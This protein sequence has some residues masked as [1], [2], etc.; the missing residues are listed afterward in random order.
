MYSHKLYIVQRAKYNKYNTV[1]MAV[2]MHAKKYFLPVY[3]VLQSLCKMKN[4]SN[5]CMHNILS[6]KSKL[7]ACAGHSRF[8][9]CQAQEHKLPAAKKHLLIIH[10][11]SMSF[12]YT[13][14]CSIFVGLGI[15][16]WLLQMCCT[17]YL[18]TRD[19][20]EKSFSVV[21]VANV[22]Y[23]KISYSDIWHFLTNWFAQLIKLRQILGHTFNLNRM[24]IL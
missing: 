10:C 2:G 14:A 8:F 23:L 9:T 7:C 1:L 4:V 6:S 12:L 17:S 15:D 13:W 22:L 18:D 24:G 16:L 3:S 19:I 5:V 21:V 20:L 11:A